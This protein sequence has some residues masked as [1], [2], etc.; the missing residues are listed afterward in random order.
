MTTASEAIAEPKIEESVAAK[1]LRVVGKLPVQLFLAFVGLLWL[2]PTFGL[3]ITFQI[4]F[5][6][7]LFTSHPS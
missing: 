5:V 2:I 6:D 4:G 3:F 1:I 7:G